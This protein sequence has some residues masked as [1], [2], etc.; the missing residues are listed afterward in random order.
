[1]ALFGSNEQKN[2]DGAQDPKSSAAK[3]IV[4]GGTT[5]LVALSLLTG[6][7]F[8]DPAEINEEQLNVNRAPIVMDVDDYLN[9]QLEDDDDDAD[10][11]KGAKQGVVARF[12]QA[13]LS[14]PSAVRLLIITPL[15]LLGTA[16]MTMVSFLWNVIFASPLGAFIASFAMGFAVL[17]GLF[18]ATA[19]ILFPEIPL[20]KILSKRNILILAIAALSLAGIDAVAPL[21]WH[22]YPAV[23]ALVKLGIGATVIGVLTMR[24]KALFDSLKGGI[25][26]VKGLPAS[27]I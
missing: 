14:L 2:A 21:F 23:S 16:L 12:K 9:S 24:T 20:N 27:A 3:N 25:D 6:I 15:W 22:Q 11:Q 8:S 18:A 5:A 10:E 13:V 19:K 17:I 1:M 4:K 7:G 26:K